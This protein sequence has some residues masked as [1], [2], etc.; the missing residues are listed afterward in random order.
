MMI[1][2]AL[3]LGL[4]MLGA[5]S[6]GHP[7]SLYLEF[8]PHTRYVQHAPFSWSTFAFLIAFALLL[9]GLFLS[10]YLPPRKGVTPPCTQA[11]FPG[12]A[13]CRAYS[14]FASGYWRGIDSVGL[15]RSKILRLLPYGLPTWFS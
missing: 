5:T 14:T 8:P 6:T 15:R 13:G 7:M 1:L 11:I 9:G 2:T 3:L 10:V 4:P 12:G